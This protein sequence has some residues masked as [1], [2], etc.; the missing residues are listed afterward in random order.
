MPRESRIDDLRDHRVVV[1]VYAGE[2]RLALFHFADEIFA[3]FLSNTSFRD[4]LFRPLTVAKLTKIFRQR[5]HGSP[6]PLEAEPLG[7]AH[8]LKNRLQESSY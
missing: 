4:F 8:R 2:E 6:V 1:A 5:T 3:Q 7:C